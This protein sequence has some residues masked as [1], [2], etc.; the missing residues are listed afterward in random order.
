MQLKTP[1]NDG[2][3]NAG[4]HQIRW[5]I[6]RAI[7]FRA[8]ADAVNF[9]VVEGTIGAPTLVA[10]QKISAPKTFDE[11]ASL[12][13]YRD[14]IRTMIEQY[15]PEKA[16]VRYPEPNARAGHSTSTHR[17]IRI[18]GVILEASHSEKIVIVT[19]SLVTM[20]S[21][22]GTESA[23]TAK[24]YIATDDLR[25]LDWTELKDNSREAVLAAVSALE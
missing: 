18:E 5:R 12:A 25:G 23:K 24:A 8:E 7:G 10:H 11:P 14:R 6:M 4:K 1:Q 22:L 9:A 21:R 15:K 17:R 19:G 20:A 3:V 16:A 13:W 2:M